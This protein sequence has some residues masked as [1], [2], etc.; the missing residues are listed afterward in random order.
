ML[1]SETSFEDCMPIQ[2]Y[3]VN[4]F[5]I[6]NNIYEGGIFLFSNIVSKWTGFQDFSFL[7]NDIIDMEILFI[8]T[9]VKNQKLNKK[10]N[11]FL[12]KKNISFECF[13]TP[14]ACRAFN[15]TIS[16][17]RKAGALLMPI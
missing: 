13:N 10:F 4:S 11:D 6:N 16:S 5:N 15:I 8:G 17:Q 12:I 7:E 14:T 2:G 9:G 1:F 3:G